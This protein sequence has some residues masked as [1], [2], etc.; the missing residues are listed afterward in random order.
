LHY[1]LTEDNKYWV[2]FL[3][4]LRVIEAGVLKSN[5]EN[6]STDREVDERRCQGN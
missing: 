3:L 5:F 2:L 6:P 4:K 1:S